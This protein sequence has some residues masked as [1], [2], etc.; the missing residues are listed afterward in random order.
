MLK[1]LGPKEVQ[2]LGPEK[3]RIIDGGFTTC[4][5]P[6]PRWDVASGSVTL[7]LDDATEPFYVQTGAMELVAKIARWLAPGG[8]AVVTEFGLRA[9]R[10]PLTTAEVD[11]YALRIV[12]AMQRGHQ[13]TQEVPQASLGTL[14]VVEGFDLSP[15]GSRITYIADGPDKPPA[16]CRSARKPSG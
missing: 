8:T 5:Q 16:V 2:K 7:N 11:R 4:A 6:T 10:R 12:D 3:Y 13:L 9:F 15:D 1:L 14:A